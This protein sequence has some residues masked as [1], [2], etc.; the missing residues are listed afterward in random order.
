M[1]DGGGVERAIVI[2]SWRDIVAGCDPASE[3]RAMLRQTDSPAPR[4]PTR[5]AR[6][7]QEELYLLHQAAP[8]P[9]KVEPR[10]TGR[11]DMAVL[12]LPVARR[13]RPGEPTGGRGCPAGRG[14]GRGP[15][16]I[17]GAGRLPPRGD[18]PADRPGARRGVLPG[19]ST[20]PRIATAR[21]H[22]ALSARSW[23]TSPSSTG[24]RFPR[25]MLSQMPSSVSSPSPLSSALRS[26]GSS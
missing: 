14:A 1:H 4:N 2:D 5:P 26:R 20:A 16:R 19:R 23:S 15:P 9:E 7:R 11:G 18:P 21:G 25:L 12:F 13:E 17:A 10:Q 22:A 8:P 6:S 24:S 3:V